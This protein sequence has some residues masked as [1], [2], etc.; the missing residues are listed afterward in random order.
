MKYV[1]E[2]EIEHNLVKIVNHIDKLNVAFEKYNTATVEDEKAELHSQ[3]SVLKINQ[4]PKIYPALKINEM[5]TT[6]MIAMNLK[7]SDLI[8][9]YPTLTLNARDFNSLAMMCTTY[10]YD[11]IID[12]LTYVYNNY[13]LRYK[14]I[15]NM[16]GLIRT[17]ILS[18]KNSNFAA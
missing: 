17:I 13:L 18:N 1:L 15:Y 12:A 11:I 10:S 4:A 7:F 14:P 16:G 3:L 2:Q 6:S 5:D 8:D 9:K